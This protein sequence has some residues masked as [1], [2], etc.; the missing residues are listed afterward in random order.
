MLVSAKGGDKHQ[1]LVSIVS[2]CQ[3]QSVEIGPSR[4][5]A[6]LLM[7]SRC[8]LHVASVTKSSLSLVLVLL[9]KD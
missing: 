1:P 4:A 6:L 3:I 9:R 7:L 5:E 8:R 2:V